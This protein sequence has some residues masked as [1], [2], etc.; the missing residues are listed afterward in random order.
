M[1]KR[2]GFP[3]ILFVVGVSGVVLLL[4]L[5]AGHETA[6]Q[7]PDS[8]RQLSLTDFVNT[9]DEL[10]TGTEP[11]SDELWTEIRSQSAERLLGAIED[12]TP[13]DYDNLVNLYLWGRA[14]LSAEQLE[15]A[16]AGLTPRAQDVSPW[17][18]EKMRSVQDRMNQA[19]M[20]IDS[21]HAL[22][23]ARTK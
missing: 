23:L 6:G 1:V 12:G 4:M 16:L 19:G 18:Y 11:V 13:A 10:V 17:A 3:S 9:I 8:W 15:A 21:N 22:T 2:Y 5:V 7:S 14:D 20:P